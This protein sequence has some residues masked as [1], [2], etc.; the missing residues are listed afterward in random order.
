MSD[1]STTAADS[2]PLAAGTRIVSEASLKAVPYR[3]SQRFGGSGGG[4]FSDDLTE[5]CRLVEVRVRSG[6]RVDAIQCVWELADG[7]TRVGALHGGGGG[8]EHAFTLD[9]GEYINRVVLRSGAE[10]DQLTFYTSEGRTHGPY[11]GGGGGTHEISAPVI[12]GFFGRSGG[13]LDALGAFSPTQ[14]P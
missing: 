13:R 4:E 12:T 7:D 8:G 1:P 9:H 11:G 5:V 14:C 3:R 10:I 6:A 2:I